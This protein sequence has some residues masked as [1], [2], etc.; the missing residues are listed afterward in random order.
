MEV[1]MKVVVEVVVEVK[2]RAEIRV[3]MGIGF[4]FENVVGFCN[5]DEVDIGFWVK[6]RI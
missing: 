3:R 2:A 4:G 5:W 1:D 6:V